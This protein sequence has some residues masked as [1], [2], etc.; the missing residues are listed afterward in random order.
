[1]YVVLCRINYEMTAAILF[2]AMY[3][4]NMNKAKVKTPFVE[5]LTIISLRD[6]FLI[7]H[8]DMRN[9]SRRRHK[10]N[11]QIYHY[12]ILIL[13]NFWFNNTITEHCQAVFGL[14]FEL[15]V[16]FMYFSTC[17]IFTPASSYRHLIS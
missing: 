6:V 3:K 15:T 7:Y 17:R 1:M 2:K 8:E 16:P 5:S 9:I 11:I 14:K 13:I 4:I 12:A 10:L